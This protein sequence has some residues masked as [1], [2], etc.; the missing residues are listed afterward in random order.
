VVLH[1][2][3]GWPVAEVASILGCAT[4]T[5]KVHL[6]RARKRL[7]TLLGEEAADVLG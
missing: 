3:E 4:P 6:H 2:L 7:G 1:Y 5:A